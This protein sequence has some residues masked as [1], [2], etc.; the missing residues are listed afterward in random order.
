MDG[1]VFDFDGVLA[2]SM[3]KH[4]QAY[5]QVLAPFGVQVAD[6]DVYNLE[7]ARSETILRD[8]APNL[9]LDVAQLADAKQRAFAALGPVRLYP[10]AAELAAWCQGVGPTGLVTGTRRSNLERLIPELLPRFAAVMTQ[11]SYTQDKPHPEPY[12]RAAAAMELDPADL[13]AVENAK[14]GVASAKAA[15]YGRVVAITTTLPAEALGE[16]DAIVADHAALRAHLKR[17]LRS[18]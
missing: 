5:R 9:E 13:I 2:D 3:G 14:R 16:A 12:A 10:G 4:A 8:L 17:L 15:G 6:A 18:A 11:E 7:G 1:V